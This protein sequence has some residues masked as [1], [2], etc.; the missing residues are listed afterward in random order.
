MSDSPNVEENRLATLLRGLLDLPHEV[1][2]VEFKHNNCEPDEIGEY[3]SALA[4][5]AGL[6]EKRAAFLAWGIEDGTHRVV[7][8]LFQPRKR[9]IGSEDLEP[10]LSRHLHP[11]V[12][13]V[14]HEL[15][16]ESYKV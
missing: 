8:T 7:G 11:D 14:V 1:E 13:F 10:W 2:W 3:V 4:N 5:A 12:H 9:K 6:Q 15:T 16:Y